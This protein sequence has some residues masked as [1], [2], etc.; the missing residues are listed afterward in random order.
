MVPTHLSTEGFHGIFCQILL[1]QQMTGTSPKEAQSLLVPR[2]PSS[3]L[4]FLSSPTVHCSLK[5]RCFKKSRRGQN[6]A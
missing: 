5:H 4:F 1:N 6:S 2:V 3:F